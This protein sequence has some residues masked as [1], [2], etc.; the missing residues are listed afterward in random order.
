MEKAYRN[1]L[2]DNFQTHKILKN[3]SFAYE[4]YH[5]FF[6]LKIKYVC[7]EYKTQATHP[8]VTEEDGEREQ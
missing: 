8:G 4:I 7:D 6:K 3:I 2:A 1:S 5:L